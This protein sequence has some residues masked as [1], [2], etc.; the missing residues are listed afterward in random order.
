MEIKSFEMLFIGISC[1]CWAEGYSFC[2][3]Q[4]FIV[5]TVTPLPVLQRLFEQ[6]K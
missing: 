1:V 6:V 3:F 5:K 2:Y 4:T